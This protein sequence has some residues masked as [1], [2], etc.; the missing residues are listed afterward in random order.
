M[1]SD[2]T[3]RIAELAAALDAPL[4][5][6]WQPVGLVVVV[7]AI[8]G[9]GLRRITTCFA[10]D[11]MAWEAAG[12]LHTATRDVDNALDRIRSPLPGG[13]DG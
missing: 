11:V 4:P 6:G 5:D 1:P 7:R 8:D 10:G 13:R 2:G 3:E 12:M 9:Q